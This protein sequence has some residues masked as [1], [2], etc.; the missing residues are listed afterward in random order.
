MHLPWALR[1]KGRSSGRMT[2]HG[3]P[4]HVPPCPCSHAATDQSGCGPAWPTGG[5]DSPFNRPLP[6]SAADCLAASRRG[7]SL[8]LES[9]A[10]GDFIPASF[11]RICGSTRRNAQVVHRSPLRNDTTAGSFAK[12]IP[13]ARPPSEPASVLQ[14]PRIVQE[15][16]SSTFGAAIETWPHNCHNIDDVI[17]WAIPTRRRWPRA[18]EGSWRGRARGT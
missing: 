15:I 4:F 3:W 14:S 11:L 10:G 13:A 7:I 6:A 9:P 17:P 5:G 2:I 8:R 18:A 1:S 12:I 16:T